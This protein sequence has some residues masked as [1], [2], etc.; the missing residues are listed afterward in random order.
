M[1]RALPVHLLLPCGMG[2]RPN[3]LLRGLVVCVVAGSVRAAEACS[4][5]FG[6]SDS[7]HVQG[8]NNAILF[9]LTVTLGVLAAFAVFF[10]VLWRRS[11]LHAAAPGASLVCPRGGR[12][13]NNGQPLAAR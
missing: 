13:E 2:D 5:C 8:M 7:P 4:V 1:T 10:V 11:R 3:G 6:N 12:A 9:L